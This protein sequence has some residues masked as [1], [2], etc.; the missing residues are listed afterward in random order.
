MEVS[1]LYDANQRH[2]LANGHAASGIGL[3]VAKRLIASQKWH[4]HI[5]DFNTTRGKD[6]ITTLGKLSTF[7]KT[8]V[9]SYDSVGSSF[10]DVFQESKRIDFVFA[11]AGIPESTDFFKNGTSKDVSKLPPPPNMDCIDVTL[12]GIINTS[13]IAAHFF[14]HSPQSDD[15]PRA[16]VITASCVSLYASGFLPIY[17]ASKHG[18]LGFMRAIAARLN[19]D[20]GIRVNALLPGTVKTNMMPDEQWEKFPESH[21]TPVETCVDVVVDLVE[22]QDV[23]MAVETS[24][25]NVYVR[26]QVE[27]CDEIAEAILGKSQ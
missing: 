24:G 25:K 13:Q 21:F 6:A 3:A 23:G 15:S 2:R 8:N 16:L 20:D 1:K 12:G 22:S 14:R 5:L 17:T 10:S 9:A 11:N 26:E 27:F 18:V 7:H 19:A 4:V